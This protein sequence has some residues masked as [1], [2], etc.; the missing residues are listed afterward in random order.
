[1]FLHSGELYLP[2][3]YCCGLQLNMGALQWQKK[4]SKPEAFIWRAYSSLKVYST[5]LKY[6]TQTPRENHVTFWHFNLYLL[7]TTDTVVTDTIMSDHPWSSYNHLRIRAADLYSMSELKTPVFPFLHQILGNR[8]CIRG[9]HFTIFT[10]YNN[11]VKIFFYTV[12]M[13]S[14]VKK[15]KKNQNKSLF[16][17]LYPLPKSTV[18]KEGNVRAWK[19]KKDWH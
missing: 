6:R 8:F 16:Q 1:M 19:G 17:I 18:E 11:T 9:K 7:N 5:F 12:L 15:R 14:E 4:K 3:F 13:F 2:N 10:N